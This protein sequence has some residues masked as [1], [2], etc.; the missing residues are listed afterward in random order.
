MSFMF[1][2]AERFD[3]NLGAWDVSSVQNMEGTF[4]GFD[5]TTRFNGNIGAWDVSSVTNMKAMFQNNIAFNQDV[6]GWDVFSVT[7]MRWMFNGATSFNQDIGGWDVSS[8]IDL[9]VMF[10]NA[11]SFNQDLNGWDVSA[12]EDMRWAFFNAQAFNQDIGA[13]DVSRATA[14]RAMFA[15]ARN[16][17]QDIGG[18]DVSSVTDMQYMFRNALNFDQDLG[19]WDVSNV[20]IFDSPD[21]GGFLEGVILSPVNYDALLIGWEALDLQDGLQFT[22]NKSRYTTAAQAA[23]AA[24]ISDD[25]WTI[26]DAGEISSDAFVTTWEVTG[27]AGNRRLRIGTQG[28]P[29]LTDYN[30]TINWGDGT[31]ENVTGDDPDPLHTYQQPGTYVVSITGT[32]AS[33]RSRSSSGQTL[34]SIDQWGSIQWESM[35]S[36]FEGAE[37]MTYAATDAPDLSGVASMLVDV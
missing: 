33:P 17:N 8:V 15:G 11:A 9:A 5:T 36:A 26:I 24:I 29:D 34:L 28:G 1:F 16:F 6:S 3:Q 30:F 19:G 22:A 18:W 31:S 7:S 32:F 2:E 4:G 25:N 35:A 14:M 10:Q 21:F 37:S 23:R 27:P 13:W 20:T 12:V